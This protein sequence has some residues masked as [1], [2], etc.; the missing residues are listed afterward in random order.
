MSLRQRC[1]YLK[2]YLPPAKAP[3]S[4]EEPFLVDEKPWL[5]A[6]ITVASRYK[7]AHPLA[8]ITRG[9]IHLCGRQ[10]EVADPRTVLFDGRES[11]TRDN[12][13]PPLAMGYHVKLCRPC[14]C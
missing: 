2:T 14:R 3:L 1:F 5:T 10:I 6:P 9:A 11:L 4:A 12:I 13:S 7:Q 8:W